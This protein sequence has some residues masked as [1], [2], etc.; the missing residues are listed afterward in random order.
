MGDILLI[1]L[2]LPYHCDATDLQHAHERSVNSGRSFGIPAGFLRTTE[3]VMDA[4]VPRLFTIG[5]AVSLIILF[6]PS[7]TIGFNN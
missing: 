1:F 5:K 6:S 2:L 4:D 3:A 7:L